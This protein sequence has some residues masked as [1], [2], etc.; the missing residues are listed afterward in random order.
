MSRDQEATRDVGSDRLGKSLMV[1]T[2][3][4][5]VREILLIFQ[6]GSDGRE[7]TIISAKILSRHIGVALG[8]LNGTVEVME[9]VTPHRVKMGIVGSS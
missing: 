7:G 2:A 5:S 9:G 8:T 1:S 4:F 3:A 6:V